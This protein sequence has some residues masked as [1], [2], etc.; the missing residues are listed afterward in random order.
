MEM[1]KYN[2]DSGNRDL[3]SE[4][5]YTKDTP[6]NEIL[7]KAIE[8]KACLI[9]KTSYINNDKPGAWYIKGY[10]K[11]YTYQ[12]IKSKIEENVKEIN[13][14]ENTIKIDKEIMHT[15]NNDIIFEDF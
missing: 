5:S 8:L 4:K 7:Q 12:E 14:T 13:L 2:S 10:N 3:S 15:F 11:H 9:V 1:T 6:S